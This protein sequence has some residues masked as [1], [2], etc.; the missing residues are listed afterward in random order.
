MRDI[1]KSKQSQSQTIHKQESPVE[2]KEI[3]QIDEE[4]Q[5]EEE[6]EEKKESEAD[7]LSQESYQMPVR[8][9]N[10]IAV[11]TEKLNM[12][13]RMC[14]IENERLGKIQKLIHKYDAGFP[15][16]V[17]TK[18]VQNVPLKFIV[19]SQFYNYKNKF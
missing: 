5:I 13:P 14:Q 1:I 10:D 17:Y 15:F 12:T 16:Q 7:S 19:A 9:L 3:V 2:K 4:E 11:W 6:K 18:E 8:S